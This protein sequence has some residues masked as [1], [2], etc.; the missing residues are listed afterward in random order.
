MSLEDRKEN[1]LSDQCWHYGAMDD[2]MQT[3]D[4]TS[5][6]SNGL[7]REGKDIENRFGERK[8]KN[9]KQLRAVWAEEMDKP[10]HLRLIRAGSSIADSASLRAYHA[11]ATA[12]GLEGAP[13]SRMTIGGIT[14]VIVLSCLG[15]D[16]SKSQWAIK[17]HVHW[18]VV[19]A[20]E[21]LYPIRDMVPQQGP[22]LATGKRKFTP[23]CERSVVDEVNTR[24]A[25]GAFRHAWRPKETEAPEVDRR[26]D[27]RA[28]Q[29]KL[30]AAKKAKA[31]KR[32]KTRR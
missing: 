19:C 27:L 10:Y 9:G 32:Q 14:G 8:D 25:T 29:V 1:G 22:G 7:F 12:D 6:M 24:L 15:L 11:H 26:F 2:D 30:D 23:G 21:F 18:R 16:G 17:G 13:P 4:V 28:F 3:S 20:V 31:H 5:T